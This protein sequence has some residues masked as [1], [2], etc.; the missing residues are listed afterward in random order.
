MESLREAVEKARLFLNSGSFYASF[1]Y[2][3]DGNKEKAWVR[4][5]LSIGAR[6]YDEKF[7]CPHSKEGLMN[8]LIGLCDSYDADAKAME[9]WQE[10]KGDHE[11]Y[12]TYLSL[13]QAIEI[14]RM[15]GARLEGLAMMA[16]MELARMDAAEAA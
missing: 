4:V 2:T 7:E 6:E 12:R 16:R 15:I 13:S 1:S 3:E 10:A 9:I 11:S 5:M 8:G 14:A